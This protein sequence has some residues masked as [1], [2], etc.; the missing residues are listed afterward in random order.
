M[1][2]SYFLDSP[3]IVVSRLMYLNNP[4]RGI[5]KGGSMKPG[6]FTQLYVHLVISPKY[7]ER[8]LVKEIRSEV[9]KYIS[10]ILTNRGHKSIII[11]GM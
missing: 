3:I 5:T 8:L 10:G 4:R 9:F 11:N 1:T 7:R 6:V 2:L